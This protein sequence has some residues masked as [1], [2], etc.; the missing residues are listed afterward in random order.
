MPLR[1]GFEEPAPFDGADLGLEEERVLDGFEG[2]D[3]EAVAGLVGE[4]GAAVEALVGLVDEEPHFGHD[5]PRD[6][7]DDPVDGDLD[8]A[9]AE[10]LFFEGAVAFFDPLFFVFDGE[11]GVLVPPFAGV[12]RAVG[13]AAEGVGDF[14]ADE[15][16]GHVGDALF[17]GGG[18]GHAGV[19]VDIVDVERVLGVEA[20][21]EDA[22]IGAV[23][24]RETHV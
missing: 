5:E 22:W 21:F 8:V 6:G 17:V 16:E 3:E 9:V 23:I 12:R 15:T 14:E 20:V 1:V 4:G 10:V 18:V 2:G 11:F 24:F 19:E 7:A 13:Y